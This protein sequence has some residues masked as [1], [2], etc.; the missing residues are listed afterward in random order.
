MVRRAVQLR[1]DART[2]VGRR[3]RLRPGDLVGSGTVGGGCLL[4]IRDETLGRVPGAGRRRDARIE[5]LGELR[6][7]I[8]ERP[9]CA[10]TIVD[11]AQHR[12]PHACRPVSTRRAS[13]WTSTSS[14]RMRGGWPTARR[15]RRRAPAAHQDPQERRPRPTPA[16]RR[17]GRDHGR[18]ARRGRGD[19]RRR[20][21][22]GV[23][24]LSALGGRRKASASDG[25]TALLAFGRV[26]SARRRGCS[27]A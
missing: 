25:C 27:P 12:M 21:R 10:M 2:C 24:R 19:G 6:T 23:R 11:R 5:Q 9:R 7:P 22:R 20:D 1:P 18:D 16:R 26:D 15:R 3:V 13:S 4:E 8:V 14:R 17:R